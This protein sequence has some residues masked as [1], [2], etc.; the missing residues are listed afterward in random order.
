MAG[1][2]MGGGLKGSPVRAGRGPTQQHQ[3]QKHR[4]QTKRRL[5]KKPAMCVCPPGHKP[6]R[7]HPDRKTLARQK[8]GLQPLHL[9]FTPDEDE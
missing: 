9:E 3:R 1:R 8:A 4:Y 2:R 5:K 7:V 6:G